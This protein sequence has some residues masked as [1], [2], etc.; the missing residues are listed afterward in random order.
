MCKDIQAIVKNK[1]LMWM[2][3]GVDRFLDNTEIKGDRVC[4]AS[5]PRVG[6][7][8]LRRCLEHVT[9]VTTGSDMHLF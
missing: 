7:T 8:F 6:N 9:G 2:F 3:D 1:E 5:Y 4:F